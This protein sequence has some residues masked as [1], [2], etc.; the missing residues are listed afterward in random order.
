[1]VLLWGQAEKPFVVL[2]SI[3]IL[4]VCTAVRERAICCENKA[5]IE[6]GMYLVSFGICKFCKIFLSLIGRLIDR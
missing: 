6:G 4:S 1:M 2:V 3:F 5:L